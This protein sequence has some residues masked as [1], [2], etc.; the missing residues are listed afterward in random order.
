MDFHSENV[1]SCMQLHVA[2]SCT[3]IQLDAIC[4]DEIEGSKTFQTRDFLI[5]ALNWALI[6]CSGVPGICVG[7]WSSWEYVEIHN[8]STQSYI[9]YITRG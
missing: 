3:V 4:L 7:Q 1:V 8:L 2:L 6:E 5:F 9:I